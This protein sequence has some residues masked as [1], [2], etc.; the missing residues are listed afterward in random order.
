MSCIDLKTI[1]KRFQ[2]LGGELVYKNVP[3]PEWMII[4]LGW[5]IERYR[6]TTFNYRVVENDFDRRYPKVNNSN[7]RGECE[8]CHWVAYTGI[9]HFKPV[10]FSKKMAGHIY[11]YLTKR[12]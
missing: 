4:K 9:S 3:L 10:L 6:N 1:G 5:D 7:L 11:K 2:K 8:L 12:G